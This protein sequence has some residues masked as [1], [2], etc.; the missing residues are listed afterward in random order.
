MTKNET[1]N[2]AIDHLMDNGSLTEVINGRAFSIYTDRT[3]LDL[4]SLY[5]RLAQKGYVSAKS[6][7]T[8][9]E[10]HLAESRKRAQTMK[11]RGISLGRKMSK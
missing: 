6:L 8:A 7:A 4:E 3:R 1:V 5:D 9:Y 11:N 2:Y 10:K